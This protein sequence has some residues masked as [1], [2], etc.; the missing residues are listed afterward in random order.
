MQDA[1]I[2]MRNGR[3]CVPVKQENKSQIPGMIH[4]Q[5]SSGSTVFV[6]PMAVVK[7]NNEIRELEIK[8]QKEI[9][10]ILAR[11]SNEAAEHME[12]LRDDLTV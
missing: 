4:D 11:L 6:E 1:V 9:E 2:T 3:Y 10:A 5:S 8:E 12:Q 7:L